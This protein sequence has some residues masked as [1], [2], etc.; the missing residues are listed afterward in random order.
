[1]PH[2]WPH[3]A[4][5]LDIEQWADSLEARGE[6]PRLIRQVIRQTN[7]QVVVLDVGAGEATGASGYDGIVEAQRGSPFVPEG[8]SVWELGTGD[9]VA[10]KANEDYAKRTA[11]P[12]GVVPEETTFVFV[13]CRR[14]DGKRDWEKAK[15][16]Q[17]KWRNIRAFDVQDIESAL[18][19][20]PAAHI[21]LSEVLGKP[22]AGVE[23]LE[24][25]WNRFSHSTLP[26]LSPEVVLAGRA[27]QAGAFLR[28]LD[29]EPH[30][31][32][33]SATSTDDV[34]AFVAAVLLT[35]P[36]GGRADLL[37]RALIVRDAYSLRQLD[38]VAE[39]LLL[40]PFDEDLRRDAL[41][42]RSH[43]VVLLSEEGTPADV[44][45]PAVAI[46]SVASAFKELGVEEEQATRLAQAAN[47]SLVAFQREA[48]ARPGIARRD[49]A[50][51][52][53]SKVVRRAWLA[54]GW[55]EQRSGDIDVL[56]E[57]LGVAYEDTR[58][59]LL[60]SARGA[61]PL[62]VVSGQQWGRVLPEAAWP[63]SQSLLSRADFDA[64]ER[65]IQSVL[66]SVDPAL[67]LPAEDRWTASLHGKTRIHSSTLR[68][69]LAA[70][71]ALAGARGVAVNLGNGRT[72]QS[73]AG[74][75]VAGLLQRAND[76]AS[77]QLWASLSDVLPLLAEAAPDVFLRAVQEATEG[78][79]PVM[80]TMFMDQSSDVLS[81][82]S[83][84][85]GLLWALEGVAWS[86]DH[87]GLAVQMLA[88][89]AEL[90]PG[91]RLSNRPSASLQS[92][93]RTW[94]PQTSAPA[95]ARI[96]MIDAICE[97]HADVGWALLLALLPE[98]YA[99]GA[100]THAP[101][102]RSW[103]PRDQTVTRREHWELSSEVA[104]RVVA[105]AADDA[106]RWVEVVDRL[107]DLPPPERDAAL[108]KLEELGGNQSLAE[109][110][111]NQIWEA[112]GKVVRQHKSFADADWAMPTDV[113]DR[114]ESAAGRFAPANPIAEHRW[115]FD[116]HVP[117]LGEGRRS[118]LE[119][120][121][122]R[123]R[124]LRVAAVGSIF[125]SGGTA[126]LIQAA[127][128]VES[129]WSIGYVVARSSLVVDESSILDLIDSPDPKRAE[130][131]FSY[132]VG[133]T[134]EEGWTYIERA[135]GMLDGRTLGQARILRTSD[136]LE[137]AWRVAVELG[138]DVVKA[139]WQEFV[140]YGR[141]SD[142]KLINE[143]AE[144]LLVHGRIA[145]AIDILSM[146]SHDPAGSADPDLVARVLEALISLQSGD[147]EVRRISD[148][149]IESLLG[150]VRSRIDEE[151][152]ALLEW[153]LL[154]ALGPFSASPLLH[155]RL[156]RD[157]EFFVQ[158][159]SLCFRPTAGE[160]DEGVTSAIA[161]N[162]WHLLRE[163]KIV[164]GS[165]AAG[166][167]IDESQL[168]Q[169]V[170][171]TRELLKTAD[172]LDVGDAYIGHILAHAPEDSDGTWPTLPVR[173]IIEVVGSSHIENGFRTE[174]Y[175]KRG[176]HSRGLTDGGAQE[177][178]LAE[179]YREL[180]L[181]I[182]EG[183]PRTAAVLRTIADGYESE[184]R[185]HDEQSERFLKGLDI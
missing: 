151:R 48:P 41:L 70:T 166:G 150:Y 22:V 185:M 156:A 69:G 160:G 153:R 129:P 6:L 67:E 101:L 126:A 34:I 60:R 11:D 130:L 112:T 12:L 155:R 24:E 161:S 63:Y 40:V 89:L 88:R 182:S 21:W 59:E 181:R 26:A 128:T 103:K 132:A 42:V 149:E 97:R 15:R 147:A 121:D 169:W 173:T 146:Y 84:H 163:W 83:A 29:Q 162:A 176:T 157:P 114:L 10:R 140:P 57:L 53:S 2:R 131:A 39:L 95:E 32:T 86:S 123:L 27:D 44:P 119:N 38:A 50:Q 81:V 134:A 135:L 52:F 105:A 58:D 91:G 9:D 79:S 102:F 73:W 76:D 117:Q 45:L 78:M 23:T 16:E 159:I 51:N 172:R 113:V 71:L 108:T 100:H 13:T 164:P 64:V 152:A 61:D 124:E 62:L 141:G 175:N 143:V 99:V 37:A 28:F 72:A 178:D 96:R 174:I 43:H 133:R 19:S 35:S 138:G 94:L 104:R 116:S 80:S 145:A 55:S 110:A 180:A 142:F 118:E 74:S 20:A 47:R 120:Y 8:K 93:F 167:A 154:P 75:T 177:R 36:E 115:L 49:W 136:E 3:L 171:T 144:Q 98:H 90:D 7:D 184:A 65:V 170:A 158:I 66:G 137:R 17:G 31:V 5:A 68:N 183:W 109:S 46:V 54:G 111:R 30:L 14:W 18:E 87:V 56:T 179:K 139:Y 85:T 4:N 25:W 106:A 125:E 168:Q 107:S 77:G 82:S 1:M 92:I 33:I 127:E 165:E 148:Y 122:E